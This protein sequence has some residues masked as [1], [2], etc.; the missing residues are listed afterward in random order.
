M[1]LQR[2]AI[3]LFCVWDTWN[4]EKVKLVGMVAMQMKS[5][6]SELPQGVLPLPLCRGRNR[7]MLSLFA[8]QKPPAPQ[9][10]SVLQQV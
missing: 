5:C 1:A 6:V 10:D 9:H 8:E 4:I 7:H 2:E 3:A